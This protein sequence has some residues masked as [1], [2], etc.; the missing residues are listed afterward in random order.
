MKIQGMKT[1]RMKTRRMSALLLA[2][3]ML[4]TCLIGCGKTNSDDGAGGI[5]GANGTTGELLENSSG[6]GSDSQQADGKPAM[7]R[8]VEEI[9]DLGDRVSWS[10]NKLCRLSDGRIV[11]SNIYQPS[12][13]SDDNGE[14]WREDDS[15]WYDR[16]YSEG[17]FASEI[18]IGAD[19]TVAA[20]YNS[21]SYD[22]DKG[23]FAYEP[24]L[25]VIRPDGPEN[26]VDIPKSKDDIYPHNYVEIADNGRIFV[27]VSGSSDLYEVKEDGSCDYFMT[28]QGESPEL[29]QFQGN[30]MFLGVPGYEPPLIYDMEKKEYVED[31]VL[32]DFIKENYPNTYF[33]GGRRYKMYFFAGEEGVIYIAGKKGLYRHVIGGSVMEQIIDGSRYAFASYEIVAMTMLADNTFLTLFT[34]GRLARYVYDPDV[35]TVPDDSLKVYSLNDNDTI[36]QAIALY[37]IAYPGIAV[38]YEIGMEKGSSVTR[39]D[40]LKKLNT[41]IMAGEGPDVLILDDMP[42]DSYIEKGLLVDLSTILDSLDD[43]E[44]L[45]DNI[46]QEMKKDDKVYAIP[47][48][49]QIPVMAGA[50]KYISQLEDLES[51]ADMMEKLRADNPGKPLLDIYTEKGI[52]RYFAMSCVPAWTTES[53]EL[54]SEMIAQFLEQTKR[55]YDAQI[56][57]LPAEVI[58]ED[59]RKNANWLKGIGEL[60]GSIEN[61][62]YLRTLQN[63]HKYIKGEIQLAYTA[64]SHVSGYNEIISI[65]EVENFEGSKWT[66]MNGQSSNVFCAKT[67]LGIN[68]ASKRTDQAENFIRVCLGKE[69]QSNLD[70]GLAVNKAAFEENFIFDTSMTNGEYSA[71]DMTTEEGLTLHFIVYPP[72]EEQ[73]ADLRKCVEEADTPYIENTVLENVVY[74]EGILYMQGAQSLEDAVSAIE[75]KISIYLA[76]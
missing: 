38:E 56:D 25:L 40:A 50:E 32:I 76:E 22:K 46:V 16:C 52:M 37:K 65:N 12:L 42:I 10:A 59:K 70:D 13:I 33:D 35:E 71:I 73:I 11:L 53:G 61:T 20:I 67:L 6:S 26:I 23:G 5:N 58:E 17:T 30:L 54:D 48:E 74:E 18:A 72:N 21:G 2:T 28:V 60:D 3:V 29:M 34:D 41:K 57:G 9:T 15:E 44:E 49:I 36:R 69:N 7:G 27:S 55:I 1:Q 68:A 62:K 47:C 64:L 14:T 43:E 8:Y 19:N 4:L 24:K 51:I 39:E 45:F 31:E 75:K 66:V 63:A